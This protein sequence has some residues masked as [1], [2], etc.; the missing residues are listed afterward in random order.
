MAKYTVSGVDEDT[1]LQT[2]MVLEAPSQEEAVRVGISRGIRPVRSDAQLPASHAD[3]ARLVEEI[4]GLRKD[5]V[6]ISER[7]S[8][9]QLLLRTH[10][11][12]GRLAS[13]VAGGVFMGLVLF[14]VFAWVLSLFVELRLQ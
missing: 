12:H 3:I 6:A 1:G 4:Q 10:I 11:Q 7:E 13:A 9:N 14:C 2:S 8:A 5:A